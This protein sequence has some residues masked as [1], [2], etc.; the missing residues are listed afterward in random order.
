MVA[1]FILIA[2]LRLKFESGQRAALG[3]VQGF[4]QNSQAFLWPRQAVKD[5]L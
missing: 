1:W 3:S 2:H 4:S 5:G